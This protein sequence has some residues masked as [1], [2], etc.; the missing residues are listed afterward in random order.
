MLRC[1]SCFSASGCPLTG[2]LDE[3]SD[4][5]VSGWAISDTEEPA[6]ITVTVTDAAGQVV[7]SLSDSADMCRQDLIAAG[8]GDGEYG[9][10][11]ETDWDS[12]ADGLYMVRAMQM[13]PSFQE[14]VTM[15]KD[16]LVEPVSSL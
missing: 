5:A 1:C 4:T 12:L 9:F 2:A 14:A 6:E 7:Q 16:K 3:V 8:K 13:E 11:I 10:S 15:S